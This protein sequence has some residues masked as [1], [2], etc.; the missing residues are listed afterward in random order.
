MDSV[1]KIGLLFLADAGWGRNSFSF[2]LLGIILCSV[3]EAVPGCGGAWRGQVPIGKQVCPGLSFFGCMR[4]IFILP[5]AGYQMASSRR[6]GAGLRYA[7]TLAPA[8]GI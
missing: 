8:A 5:G 4:G 7:E 1:S 2:V 6:K 3:Q